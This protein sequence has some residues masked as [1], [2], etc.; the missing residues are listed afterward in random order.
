MHGDRRQLG[1]EGAA[2]ATVRA[3]VRDGECA[4]QAEGWRNSPSRRLNGEAV[5]DD[6]VGSVPTRQRAPT[7]A[8]SGRR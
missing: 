2:A 7:T 5:E 3:P 4:G 6:G 8:D 1:R